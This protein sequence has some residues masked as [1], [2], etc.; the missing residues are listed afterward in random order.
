MPT[1]TVGSSQNGRAAS[2]TQTKGGAS[3][4]TSLRAPSPVQAILDDLE[5]DQIHVQD[6][7]GEAEEIEAAAEEEELIKVQ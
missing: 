7:D 5:F 4:Q 2:S 6:K 1:T 3:H